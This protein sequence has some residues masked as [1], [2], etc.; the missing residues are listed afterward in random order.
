MKEH[1]YAVIYIDSKNN[2]K[3]LV[4]KVLQRWLHDEQGS[5]QAVIFD[6]LK[7]SITN[8]DDG[9][10]EK[11]EKDGTDSD[12]LPIH[13]IIAGLLNVIFQFQVPLINQRKK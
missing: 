8:I 10:Y 6:F 3:M 11:F 12:I 1:Y 2:K 13:Q 5:V 4:G 9:M 7:D